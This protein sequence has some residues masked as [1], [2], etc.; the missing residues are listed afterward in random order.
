[1][2]NLEKQERRKEKRKGG[3]ENFSNGD[4]ISTLLGKE[5]DGI[6]TSFDCLPSSDD[7]LVNALST[8]FEPND[9]GF[10][11]EEL[12]T[13]KSRLYIDPEVFEDLME[14][15]EKRLQVLHSYELLELSYGTSL[16]ISQTA[17]EEPEGGPEIAI[18][19]NTRRIRLFEHAH[20]YPR[21]V[22]DNR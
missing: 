19:L 17:Q 5:G 14:K 12:P 20:L 6:S 21:F 18:P 2:N 22:N 4:G 16:L 1:M 7:L 8:S 3:Q 15:L 11:S 10:D 13:K 9:S